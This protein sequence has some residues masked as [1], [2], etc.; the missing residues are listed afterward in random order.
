V[1]NEQ[2][3]ARF[4]PV[5]YSEDEPIHFWIL[6]QHEDSG[7]WVPE[8]LWYRLSNIGRAYETHVLQSINVELDSMT[9]N[10]QQVK[11]LIDEV[12][13]LKTVVNDAL[14]SELVIDLLPLFVEASR[15]QGLGI[16][17]P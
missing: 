5:E 7:K 8:R 3:S 17:G 1:T 2:F 15:K 6:G 11:N 13:F 12:E 16:E 14:I 4:D 10:E 9:L